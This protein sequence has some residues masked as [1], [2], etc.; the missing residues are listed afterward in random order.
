VRGGV[1]QREEREREREGEKE[2]EFVRS[3]L[4]GRVVGVHLVHGLEWT[5]MRFRS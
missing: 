5:R 3:C 4:R 1:R 2:R